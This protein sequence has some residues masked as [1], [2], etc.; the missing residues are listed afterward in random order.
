[1]GFWNKHH[2]GEATSSS[3]QLTTGGVNLDLLTKVPLSGFS[4]VR[5]LSS[6][7]R[8]LVVWKR[9]TESSP[10]WGLGLGSTLLKQRASMRIVGN[11]SVGKT[12]SLS[13][14]FLWSLMYLYQYGLAHI[15]FKLWV[16]IQYWIIYFC[17]RCP[18]VGHLSGWPVSLWCV[19]SFCVMR[20]SLF[21][22]SVRISFMLFSKCLFH[23]LLDITENQSLWKQLSLQSYFHMV[24]TKNPVTMSPSLS[25]NAISTASPASVN[26]QCSKTS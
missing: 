13:P 15:C 2:G 5:L 3:A 19:L 17:T 16:I 1:M 20:T 9:V 10:H 11:P 6:F 14:F 18:S 26:H 7:F 21:Y 8:T 25:Y 4:T 24:V 23:L 22:S 12:H